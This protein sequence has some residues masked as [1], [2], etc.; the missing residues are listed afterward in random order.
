MR[1]KGHHRC[2]QAAR[3]RRSHDARQQLLVAAMNAVKI[4]DRQ[5]ARHAIGG[6]WGAAMNLHKQRV[7]AMRKTTS[8]YTVERRII[9]ICRAFKKATQGAPVQFAQ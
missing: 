8:E 5:G 6:A 2:N 7:D 1:L 4:S 3:A 9:L